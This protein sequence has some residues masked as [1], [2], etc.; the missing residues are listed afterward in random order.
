MLLNI[1]VNKGRLQLELFVSYLYLSFQLTLPQSHREIQNV[2]LLH[3]LFSSPSPTN[4]SHPICTPTTT[5]ISYSFQALSFLLLPH[6]IHIYIYK[7]NTFTYLLAYI[8]A[9]THSNLYTYTYTYKLHTHIHT[10][11]CTNIHTCSQT[12]IDIYTHTYIHTHM[13]IIQSYGHTCK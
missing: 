4:Q 12:N 7:H 5:L 2:T 6:P 9:C 13:C 10:C 11:I 1:I 3:P 8:H